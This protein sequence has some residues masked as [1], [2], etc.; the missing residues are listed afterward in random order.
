MP[1]FE[2]KGPDGKIY[3]VKA[4]DA[5]S[6]ARAFGGPAPDPSLGMDTDISASL[7]E[8]SVGSARPKGNP[9]LWGTGNQAVD[10]LTMGGSTKLN[11]AGAG[12]LDATF[13]AL[14]GEGWNFSDNYTKNLEEQRANQ[15]AYADANPVR[16]GI[17]TAGGIAL[18]VARAPVWGKGVK[19]AIGTGGIYGAFG[20]ALQDADSIEDRTLN[21]LKGAGA[22]GTIG[23]GGY[24][25]GKALGWGAEKFGK[26]ISTFRAPANDKAAMEVYELIQKAGGPAAVQ[27]KLAKLGPDAALADVLGVRGTAAARNAS[28]ISPEAREILTDFVSG[29][30]GGQNQRIVGD[31][32]NLAGLPQGSTASVDDLIKAANDKTRPQI[33]AAYDAARRVGKDIPLEAFDNI[34][35]TPVGVKAF[36]QAL[37]NITS[38]AARDP[39]A[40]GNLAVLDE[41]KR[42]LDG[43]AEVARRAGDAME[44]EYRATAKALRDKID[45]ILGS[46]D[47]YSVA[48]DL[49]R[50]AY[51][52]E[53]AIKT[54][55]ALGSPR[56]S[57]SL[58]QKAG[59][60]GPADKRLLAQGYVA[61]QADSL[62]N[63]NSTEGAIGQLNTPMGKR[64][65][66][67]ALGPNALD[68]T[69]SR[70]RQFNITN[71]EIVG[72]ST[73]ARQLAEMAGQA[74]GWGGGTAGLSL[75][76][77]NDI[78]AAGLTGLLGAVG[79]RS[80]P[81]I[82]RKLVTDNQ[83]T[84]APFLAD[85]L[86]KA[87]LPTTRPIPPGF[88]EKFV[89]DGDQKLAKTLNLMWMN[90]LQ[91]TSPQTKPAQ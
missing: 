70:E 84:V 67:A 9:N 66:D 32:E 16:S 13:G 87:N 3:E 51:K 86:T 33:G 89:T 64:A 5:A 75:L 23:L 36:K 53:E 81:T 55:E 44:G 48:R 40:G 18:G 8:A 12:L 72:N 79:R 68:K 78:W 21:A 74:A 71:R 54:G 35:T 61:K 52:S 14:S 29:R 65:A 90:H 27:A 17:G 57:P 73:T 1:I 26:A 88:L 58:P 15:A 63:K 37:D 20:G 39:K 24:Y 41:T 28:N 59:N 22:G 6:A 34:I 77:G 56:I 11:A 76:M 4:P 85:I 69:L 80:I 10:T 42:M 46:G 62:L 19:G 82:A 45:E 91:N 60:F 7:P 50:A 31:M 38:R 43:Y 25:G 49:R 83:R 47:E 30:K 2:V